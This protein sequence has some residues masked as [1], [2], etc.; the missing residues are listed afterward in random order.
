[1]SSGFFGRRMN[2]SFNLGSILF[3]NLIIL[4]ENDSL[5]DERYRICGQRAEHVRKVLG[6]T[7]GNVIEVG[8]LNGPRGKGTIEVIDSEMI[9]L[10]C[11]FE[12]KDEKNGVIIDLICALPRPQTLKKLLQSAATMGIRRLHLINSKR[13]E[14]CYF[15]ASIMDKENIREHLITGLSQGRLTRLPEVVVHTRF[16]R[17]FNETLKEF[18][19]NEKFEAKRLLPDLEAE[20]YLAAMDASGIRRIL[21]AIGPEGGWLPGEVDFMARRGFEKFRLGAWPLRVENA[22]VAAMSQVELAMAGL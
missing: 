21:L 9:T 11:T 8:L 18:E 15:N 6:S 10:K 17:F 16:V 22:V 20:N 3:M 1:M 7:V 14:K 19:K 2:A 5:G 4:F 12:N 13:V